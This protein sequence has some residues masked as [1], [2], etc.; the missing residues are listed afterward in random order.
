MVFFTL[1]FQR[2]GKREFAL[3]CISFASVLCYVRI[4]YGGLLSKGK[5]KDRGLAEK[6][7]ELYVEEQLEYTRKKMRKTIL[8]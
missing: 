1:I 7:L 3:I 5:E 8:K 6:K 2:E 4:T